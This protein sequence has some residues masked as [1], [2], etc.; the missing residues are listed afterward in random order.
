MMARRQSV[1]STPNL[2]RLDHDERSFLMVK[3]LAAHPELLAEAE[4]L[5]TE[6]LTDMDASAIADAVA[7]ALRELDTEEVGNRSGR[8]RGG[9]TEPTDA[10]WEILEE[11]IEPFLADLR[12]LVELGHISAASTMAQ[13]LVDGLN[14]LG[15]LEDGTVLAWAGD[16]APSELIES[17][18]LEVSRLGLPPPEVE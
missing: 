13:G 14:E 1:P 11:A 3:L 17:V 6:L 15:D 2:D 18:Y 12:K 5:A 4:Q 10:A 9:Y 16:H 7:T 8:Y